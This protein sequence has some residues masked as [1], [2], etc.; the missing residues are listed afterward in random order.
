MLLKLQPACSFKCRT[1]LL[2]WGCPAGVVHVVGRRLPFCPEMRV[3]SDPVVFADP[4]ASEADDVSPAVTR[5]E[6]PQLCKRLRSDP[7]LSVAGSQLGDMHIAA[8]GEDEGWVAPQT[9]AAP[10]LAAAEHQP[11]QSTRERTRPGTAKAK[12]AAAQRQ[13]GGMLLDHLSVAA[14]RQ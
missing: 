13:V 2:I 12:K 4:V 11:E 10:A 14:R 9:D 7:N 8:P 1:A 5:A 6:A 3:L